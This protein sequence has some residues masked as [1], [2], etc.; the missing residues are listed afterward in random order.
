MVEL[1]LEGFKVFNKITNVTKNAY[2]LGG[3]LSFE[4]QF[5]ICTFFYKY[6][7]A[8]VYKVL[9]IVLNSELSVLL[10]PFLVFSGVIFLIKCNLYS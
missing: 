6:P 5:N 1:N 7:D 9:C 3:N 2:V 10:H 4:C 8:I